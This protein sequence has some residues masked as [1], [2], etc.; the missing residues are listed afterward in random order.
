MLALGAYKLVPGFFGMGSQ[1][2]VVV[3]IE[4]DV[5]LVN[6]GVE[7]I[8]AEDFRNLHELIVIIFSLEEGLLLKD[9]A[10]KHATQ[11]PNVKR[12]IIGLEVNKQLRALEVSGRNS[13]VVFLAGMVKF[14]QPPIN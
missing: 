12:I 13:N 3:G 1:D 14:G 9:H 4:R 10:R 11:R 5:V 6:V 8:G 2:V 7:L